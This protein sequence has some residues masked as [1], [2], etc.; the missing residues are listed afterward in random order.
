MAKNF[1][2][3]DL[4]KKK[5]TNIKSA[6]S[7]FSLA[8]ILGI[9]YI[10]R[11]FAA[12]NF[13]FHF[14]LSFTEL[15]LRLSEGGKLPSALCYALMG[16]FLIIYFAVVVLIAKDPKKLIISLGVYLFDCICLIPL[17][18]VHAQL[19]PEFFID[20]IIHFFVVLFLFVGVK[21][22]KEMKG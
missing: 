13:D 3:E 8:G 4:L 16:V 15:M 10:V 17:A 2:K 22:V 7:G 9:I 11:F 1:S 6:F 5:E 20:V 18:L 14:S 21:S 12:G 19:Q